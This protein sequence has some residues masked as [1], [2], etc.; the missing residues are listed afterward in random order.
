MF[1]LNPLTYFDL[2]FSIVFF[3]SLCCV[4]SQYNA[5]TTSTQ[6]DIICG[7]TQ[8]MVDGCF[9]DLPPHLMEF[10]QSTKVAVNK[11]EV[12]SKCM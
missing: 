6:S 11:E 3:C 8:K 10:L 5:P 12:E 7:D 2:I 9:K 1:S 4:N